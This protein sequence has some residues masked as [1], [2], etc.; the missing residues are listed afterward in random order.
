MTRGA[1]AA[2]L[3][4]ASV[5]LGGGIWVGRSTSR[6]D[7]TATAAGSPSGS[8]ARAID[9]GDARGMRP[10][11]GKMGSTAAPELPRRVTSVLPGLARDLRDPDP[12]VRRA[13]LHEAA[14]DPDTDVGILLAA[15]RDADL[16]VSFAATAALGDRYA[17]GDLAI[18]DLVDRATDH[19]L[20]ERVRM[21]ALNA[22]GSMPSAEAGALFERLARSSEVAERR[23]AA[24]MLVRQSPE[25]AVPALIELLG[26]SDEYV[27]A[28]ALASLRARARGRDFATD[29][30]AWRSWWQSQRG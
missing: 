17:R 14:H 9:L 25:I 24:V 27:R 2:A 29:A 11:R 26:D 21:V 15:S 30:A 18:G 12:N 20:P 4:G 13:A 6:A 7:A 16:E 10:A 8:A 23:A 3:L 19:V 28:N 1:L 22:I 5:L